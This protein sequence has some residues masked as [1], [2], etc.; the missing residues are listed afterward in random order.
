MKKVLLALSLFASTLSIASDPDPV[1]EEIK[2]TFQKEF[3]GAVLIK[4]TDAGDY[5]KALFIYEGYRSEAFFS[6]EGE[7]HGSARNI[8]YNQL[9]LAVTK[10]VEQRFA[11]PEV[12]EINEISSAGGTQY[13]IRLEDGTRSYRLQYD[14]GG[15][16]IGFQRLKK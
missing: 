9:P 6:P 4:W 14:S 2:K 1:N 8:L 3:P 15:N 12:L 11:K 7:F 5:F 13:L 16:N 10:A